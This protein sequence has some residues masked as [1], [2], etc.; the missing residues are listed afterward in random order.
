AGAVLV[1]LCVDP[2]LARSYGF[3][4]SAL[5]TLG[6]VIFA[7]PWGDAIAARLPA[8][9]ALLGDAIA[10]PLAAQVVCAPVIVLL[11]GNISVIAVLANLLAAPMVAI[12]T[13]AGIAAALGATVWVPLGTAL[14]W[15][16]A[17]PAV[18]IGAVAR[19]CAR[20]P[21]GQVEWID[22]GRGAWLLT[23]I[24]VL[25]LLGGP[26]LR[27]Q[28][29]RRP[30]ATVSVVV[31]SAAAF[32]PLPGHAGWPPTGPWVIVACDVGQGDA[33]VLS[34]GPGS[35]IVVDVGQE[36][37]PIADCLQ[38]LGI[39][40][41]DAVVLSHFHRDHVGGLAGVLDHVEVGAAYVS[42]VREPPAEA[43]RTLDQLAHAG[44]PAH[45]LVAGDR[46]V[47]GAVTANVV[48]P[49]ADRPTIGG[50]V[51]NNSS[52]VL[53]VRTGPTRILL[54]GDIEEEAA[55][56]VRR[57]LRGERFDVLKVAHHG[58][59]DQSDDLV[60]E[61]GASVALISVGADNT[62]G[63]PTPSALALLRQSAMLVRRTDLNGDIAVVRSGSGLSITSERDGP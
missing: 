51:P 4:L 28:A 21:G 56:S 61:S 44:V 35:A 43:A 30:A 40:R 16:G 5:A 25:L 33:I 59:A 53:D 45:P 13:I 12:T 10:I 8:R 47:W 42:P 6:L 49:Q 7:R 52:L 41:V 55:T 14:A 50:S 37:E 18:W 60:A 54:T 38:D 9:A 17:V 1:L 27:Y 20:V 3:A 63:H 29:G 46:V 57:A 62:F 48:W 34:T 11:Q 15:V 36:A 24:T 2:G 32:V 58:S 22:G 23:I 26:W 19:S 39:T 31:L